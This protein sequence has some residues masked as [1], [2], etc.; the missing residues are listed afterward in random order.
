MIYLAASLATR[1]R[2]AS[3]AAKFEERMSQSHASTRLDDQYFIYRNPKLVT[4]IGAAV[5]VIATLIAYIPAMNGK[6]IWDD[7]YYVTRNHLLTNFDGLQKIWFGVLPR[8]AEYA[9][10]QYYPLTYTTFWLEYRLWGL[11]PAGYHAVNVILHICSAMLIW[12]ILK[13]LAVPGAWLAA[14]IFALHPLNVES[15]AWIAERKNVLSVMF[16]LSSLY[17]LLRYAGIIGG[18]QRDKK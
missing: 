1:E 7:D 18:T 10:P 16:F 8:P 13:K 3:T 14:A 15:V 2:G 12:L 9:L 4:A 6:F 5:I 11:D 17:V